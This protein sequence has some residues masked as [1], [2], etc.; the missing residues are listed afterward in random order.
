MNLYYIEQIYPVPSRTLKPNLVL[1]LI[2][3]KPVEKK[4]LTGAKNCNTTEMMRKID[5]KINRV[6]PNLRMHFTNDGSRPALAATSCSSSQ[7]LWSRSP[8]NFAW[9]EYSKHVDKGFGKAST[10]FGQVL[11]LSQYLIIT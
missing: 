3:S 2:L 5:A 6:F 7:S 8:L 4:A 11:D 1:S 9:K 10:R